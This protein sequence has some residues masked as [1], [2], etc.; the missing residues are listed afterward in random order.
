MK[1]VIFKINFMIFILITMQIVGCNKRGGIPDGKVRCPWDF[2]ITVPVEV[3]NLKS[4]MKL[5]DTL[6]FVLNIPYR[7]LNLITNDSINL[8]IFKDVWGGILVSKVIHY[9][10]VT[11]SGGY[12]V[13]QRDAFIFRSELNSFEKDK[14]N[15]SLHF[16]Y[17]KTDKA[18]RITLACIAK[19][20]GTFTITFLSSGSRDAFCSN[21]FPHYIN[22]YLN[23]DFI[24]LLNEAVGKDVMP[25]NTLLPTNYYIRVE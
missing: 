9:S 17:I 1:K 19:M 3:N 2:S 24:Y 12:S 22:N 18:F 10:E 25:P 4:I 15:H 21:S 7:S 5:N 6:R 23:T 8:D 14:T 16:K 11:I 13:N 20:K